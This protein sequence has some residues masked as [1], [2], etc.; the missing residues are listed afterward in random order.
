M[1]KKKKTKILPSRPTKLLTKEK[2]ISL[3]RRKEPSKPKMPSKKRNDILLER[4]KARLVQQALKE[5]QEQE[6]IVKEERQ[7]QLHED[8]AKKTQE[9]VELER[10]ERFVCSAA[11]I[12]LFT[13]Q[14]VEA[15]DFFTRANEQFQSS[16]NLVI[17]QN[18]DARK[19]T[20]M[21][22]LIDL[23]NLQDERLDQCVDKGI[24]WEQ[25]FMFGN[26]SSVTFADGQGND[27]QKGLGI[28]IPVNKL[29]GPE[30]PVPSPGSLLGEDNATQGTTPLQSRRP[31]TW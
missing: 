17:P 26:S 23:Q 16:N 20:A 3:V 15:A 18:Y 7:R 27:W 8:A 24:D 1:K 11:A 14:P 5:Q 2:N 12:L 4:R 28:K 30:L 29:R 9:S 10:K 13:S 22:Q 21:K 6:R 25:C 31:P 19:K